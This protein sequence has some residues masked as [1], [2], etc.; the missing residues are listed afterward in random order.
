MQAFKQKIGSNAKK[1]YTSAI[2][3]PAKITARKYSLRSAHSMKTK[4]HFI[5]RVRYFCEKYTQTGLFQWIYCRCSMDTTVDLLQVQ[6]GHYSGSTAGVVWTLQ[7]IYCRCSMDTTVDLLQVQYGH[8]SGS[9]AGV[10]WTLQWIYCRCSMDTTVDLLQ[11]QY[12]HCSGSTAGVVWTLQ[13][14]YCRCSMD[15]TVDLLQ[16]QY[17]HYSGS[18]AGVVWTKLQVQYGQNVSQIG[19]YVNRQQHNLLV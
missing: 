13:W 16:V 1:D 3:V 19:N 11:V 18:T 4:R 8:Y 2:I 10:V 12:G 5:L 17:G 15:T 7:W 9:T 14:I 6:Y